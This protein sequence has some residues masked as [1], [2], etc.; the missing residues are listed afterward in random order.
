MSKRNKNR[1]QPSKAQAAQSSYV[2]K[3]TATQQRA[4]KMSSFR[5]PTVWFLPDAYA[6]IKHIVNRCN[7]EVGWIGLVESDG[8]DVMV[9][10]V[11]VPAQEVNGATCEISAAGNAEAMNALFDR[12]EKEWPKAYIG[13]WGHSH[14]N[15]GVSPSGQDIETALEYGGN[16]DAVWVMSIHNKKGDMRAD[17]YDFGSNKF[18]DQANV[19]ILAPDYPWQK[20]LNDTIDK[21]VRKKVWPQPNYNR[22]SYHRN[23]KGQFVKKP[24]PL[25]PGGPTD[26]YYSY[27]NEYA[28]AAQ[29][30]EVIRSDHLFE[31]SGQIFD[32]YGRPLDKSSNWS[33]NDYWDETTD[34]DWWDQDDNS[35]LK[36]NN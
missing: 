2:T 3:P 6:K 32:A 9:I 26:S 33:K 18:L 28:Q 12:N 10:D 35:F 5:L 4:E 24:Q 7:E 16:N 31:P 19:E 11:E 1:K 15:M 13:H 22:G 29:E 36:G 20:S 30:A 8:H 27:H 25:L 21:N 34:F 14:V 23:N 17:I